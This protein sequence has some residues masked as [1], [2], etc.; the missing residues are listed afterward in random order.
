MPLKMSSNAR[1]IWITWEAPDES[2]SMTYRIKPEMDD[3]DMLRILTRAVVTIGK[4]MGETNLEIAELEMVIRGPNAASTGAGS[5]SS[6][7]ATAGPPTDPNAERIPMTSPASLSDRPSDGGP[8]STFGWGSMPTTSVPAPLA[9]PKNG[10]WEMIP[11]E[12]M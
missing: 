8:V 11:M 10:G 6:P 3:A 2:R 5:A 9:D 1:G 7:A 12:D 4:E